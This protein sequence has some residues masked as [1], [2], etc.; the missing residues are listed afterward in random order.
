MHHVVPKRQT[1]WRRTILSNLQKNKTDLF[2][3]QVE[4][5]QDY[6]HKT[7]TYNS[8]LSGVGM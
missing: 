7:C 2:Q 8:A 5:Q 1:G 6:E 4:Q 3:C